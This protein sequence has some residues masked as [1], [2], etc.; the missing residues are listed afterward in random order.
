MKTAVS[1][2]SKGKTGTF[3]PE[4]GSSGPGR[5]KYALGNFQLTE[6]RRAFTLFLLAG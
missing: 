3:G 1:T 2:L 4:M 5:L 6:K